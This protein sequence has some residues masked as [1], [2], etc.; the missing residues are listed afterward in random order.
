M[1]HIGI[2]F[3]GAIEKEDGEGV[4]LNANF[5]GSGS[6]WNNPQ[7]LMKNNNPNVKINDSRKESKN[8]SPN[9]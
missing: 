9:S 1:G 3:G 4:L 6:I 2:E 7:V 5:S 8:N